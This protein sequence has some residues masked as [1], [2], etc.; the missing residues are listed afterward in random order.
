[1]KR[2]TF[3]SV[4]FLA[5]C[6]TK[7]VATNSTTTPVTQNSATIVNGKLFATVFQQKAAEYRALC[8]Q[9]YNIARFRLDN[10]RS[11][12]G[13]PKA[14][15]TDIDE[16]LLDNSPYQ[17]R[18][19]LMGKDY[20]PVSWNDWTSKGIADTI[21]G[22]AS[23]LKYAASQGVTIYYIT[24]REDRDR[25]GTIKN[26]SLFNLPN[27]D[28]AH[29]MQR[30]NI[31][32]KE[33]RRQMVNSAHEIVMLIGD[34]LSDFSILFD[35]RNSNDRLRNTNFSASDFGNRFI[36]LP[37]TT[38]GDWESAMYNYSKYSFIQKDSVMRSVLKTY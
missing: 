14:I 9:A 31:S 7:Q 30:Q 6:Y 11:I 19:A 2:I 34:N 26:L 33:A 4:F 16:T 5:G 22:S 15:I 24:N 28:S 18:Q 35:K 10:Y 37:N 36:L 29:Y 13:K 1:M 17:A 23:F 8:F 27:A 3:I 20:D 21:P 38:Y 25:A 12:T 32:S